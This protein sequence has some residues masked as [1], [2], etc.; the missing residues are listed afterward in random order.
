MQRVNIGIIGLGGIG[1]LLAILLSNK[2]Y[3]VF[4]SKKIKKNS[5]LSLKSKFYGNLKTKIEFDKT[6]KKSDLIFICSKYPYLKKHLKF[7]SNKKALVLPFLNGLSHFK[8]LQ[9][10]FGDKLLIS[11]I[12]KVISKKINTN[13]FIHE[14][15]NRPEVLINF[16]GTI[17]YEKKNL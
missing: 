1:G 6:L 9:K 16:S 3:K 11:K 5:I 14:S 7:I 13:L 4:T 10:K 2:G 8:I 17:K 12:G 15:K